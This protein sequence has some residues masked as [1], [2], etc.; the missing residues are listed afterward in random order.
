MH[1]INFN[2]KEI[3]MTMRK[4]PGSIPILIKNMSSTIVVER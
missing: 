1:S 2:P 3:P 4:S